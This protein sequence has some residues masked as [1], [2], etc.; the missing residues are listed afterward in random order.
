MK[1]DPN[2]IF[3]KIIAGTIPADHVYQ[4]EH[5]V[6]FLDIKKLSVGH[7][8]VIPKE[9]HRWAWDVPNA[10]AYFEVVRK[11]ALAQKKA[12]GVEMIVCKIIGDEVPHSHI[13]LIPDKETEKRFDKNDMAGNATK[14]QAALE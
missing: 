8:L 2:C 13:H 9:H 10:G 6:A 14:I 4:D 7:T 5:F 11:I 12:F 1:T 3:C